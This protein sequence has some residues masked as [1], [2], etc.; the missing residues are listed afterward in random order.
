MR[1]DAGRISSGVLF[2]WILYLVQYTSRCNDGTARKGRMQHEKNHIPMF[3]ID[4]GAQLDC[5]RNIRHK[6]RK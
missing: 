3:V 5:L 4:D 2:I 1:E 6:R